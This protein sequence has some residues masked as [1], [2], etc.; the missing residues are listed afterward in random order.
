MMDGEARCCT[1]WWHQY[2]YTGEW[3]RKFKNLPITFSFRWRRR[4]FI[5]I[6]KETGHVTKDDS[7]NDKGRVRSAKSVSYSCPP[8]GEHVCTRA[9]D[10]R[11][12][13]WPLQVSFKYQGGSCNNVKLFICADR[14][15]FIPC[16]NL[17]A[18]EACAQEIAY[19]YGYQEVREVIMWLSMPMTTFNV[20]I[21]CSTRLQISTPILEETNLFRRS[22][23]GND[24]EIVRKEMW[25]C[26]PRIMADWMCMHLQTELVQ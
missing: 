8:A 12:D 19:L 25:V 20:V 3:W 7:A 13:R 15:P 9:R 2:K 6:V 24:A 21:F 10:A 4:R 11:Y 26:Y 16:R 17:R 1:R 22:L 5:I 14:W 23:G 18:I